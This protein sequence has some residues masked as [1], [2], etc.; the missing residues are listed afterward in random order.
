[1]DAKKLTA[2]DKNFEIKELESE[3][4]SKSKSMKSH[5]IVFQ[6]EDN[7]EKSSNDVVSFSNSLNKNRDIVRKKFAESSENDSVSGFFQKPSEISKKS[8]S[9]SDSDWASSNE[10][11]S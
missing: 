4:D 6:D 8:I 7:C 1:L 11:K 10:L 3:N 2:P 5:S 9:F